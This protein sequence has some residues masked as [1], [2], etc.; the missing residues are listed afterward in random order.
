ME[1]EIREDLSLF[2][3]LRSLMLVSRKKRTVAEKVF[4]ADKETLKQLALWQEEIDKVPEARSSFQKL[5]SREWLELINKRLAEYPTLRE[6]FFEQL[7]HPT[8]VQA[9]TLESLDQEISQML[10][11]NGIEFTDGR[12]WNHQPTPQCMKQATSFELLVHQFKGDPVEK[13][14]PG[15]EMGLCPFLMLKAT[16]IKHD[17]EDS[18]E[19]NLVF[20]KLHAYCVDPNIL[21]KTSCFNK[22]EREQAERQL[23]TLAKQG[24][25][26]MLPETIA[27]KKSRGEFV[28]PHPILNREPCTPKSCLHRSDETPAYALA[29]HPDGKHNMTCL[30]AACGNTAQ[31]A[32]ID[33]KKEQAKVEQQRKKAA[34][35]ELRRTTVEHTLFA[36]E[37]KFV[38]LADPTIME[39][40][41]T[42][43]IPSWDY[44][45]MEHILTGWQAVVR[46]MIANKLGLP[47]PNA[48]EITR[49]IEGEF[50]SLITSPTEETI[51]QLFKLLR[52]RYCTTPEAYQRWLTCAIVIRSWRDE[53]DNEASITHA[54][55]KSSFP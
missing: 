13:P 50:G 34:L 54:K 26:A 55:E 19:T 8:W 6:S 30:H 32:L 11:E 14:V 38:S 44:A 25:H 33:W 31:T 3:T 4:G 48:P 49:Q 40:L 17:T 29:I 24:S 18:V 42:I 46:K 15:N 52:E 22:L 16:Y 39:K 28:W 35:H 1:N 10:I 23:D 7:R 36:P 43:V 37:N 45:T 2:E 53:T 47:D 12:T 5:L 41:E 9:R 20:D 27:E 21:K 51:S